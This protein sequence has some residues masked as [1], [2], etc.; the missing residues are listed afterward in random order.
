M[1][2]DDA[3]FETP[4]VDIRAGTRPPRT[5]RHSRPTDCQPTPREAVPTGKRKQ[6]PHNRGFE[7]R[8][9]VFGGVARITPGWARCQGIRADAVT[10]VDIFRIVAYD[11][12]SL[13]CCSTWVRAA[14]P[15]LREIQPSSSHDAR[16]RARCDSYPAY[17][18][19]TPS[20]AGIRTGSTRSF[21]GNPFMAGRGLSPLSTFAAPAFLC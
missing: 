12:M 18:C 11:V 13:N 20:H 9:P 3:W 8:P 16:A 19:S 6:H 2:A 17:G 7:A 5:A 21:F 10:V 1:V 15:I 14:W 4:C